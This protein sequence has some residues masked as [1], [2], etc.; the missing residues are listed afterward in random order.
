MLR[1]EA[2]FDASKLLAGEW[3]VSLDA[4]IVRIG[5]EAGKIIRMATYEAFEKDMEQRMF[6]WEQ[7]KRIERFKTQNLFLF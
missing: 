1:N 2:D 4:G 6:V 5:L 7:Q 3:A